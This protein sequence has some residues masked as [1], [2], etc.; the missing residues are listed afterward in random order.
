MKRTTRE[1]AAKAEGDYRP[2]TKLARGK[3]TVH[4]AVCFHCKQSAE[5]NLKA[6]LEKLNIDIEKTHALE[7]VLDVL[8]P[9]HSILRSLRRGLSFLTNFAVDPRYP[10]M[11]ATKRQAASALRWAGRVRAAC[12]TLLGLPLI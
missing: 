1:W 10:G 12:R 9:H 3:N 7:R 6:L 2:A 8:L 5:K 4:D 11:T